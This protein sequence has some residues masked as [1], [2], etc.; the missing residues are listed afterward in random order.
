MDAGG[1][2]ANVSR[3]IR[4]LGG[5]SRAFVGLGGN[6]GRQFAQLLGDAGV[7]YIEFALP[8]ETRSSM[9]VMEEVTGLHF[10]FVLPGPEQA[11]EVGGAMLA[12]LG[13]IIDHKVRYVVG[14][15][16]LLPGMD[17]G[18]YARLGEV[19][20]QRGARLIL[21]THG[22]ALKAALPG[23]PYII[24]LNEIEAR[25]LAHETERDAPVAALARALVDRQSAEV[26]IVGLGEQ[27]S[28]VT[29]AD[30]QF[31]LRQKWRCAAWWGPGTAMWRP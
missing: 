5:E 20:R 27:G 15:G 16:S 2:G 19:A 22:A 25:E 12:E 4:E 28:L 29:S 17:I 24:R 11:P 9:T 6:T 3:A 7:E 14:S 18:F 26:V 10:R 21:D 8:G 1:G 30:G 23:R 31:S 13:R